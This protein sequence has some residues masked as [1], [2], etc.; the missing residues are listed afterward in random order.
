MC[1]EALEGLCSILN[2]QLSAL[3]NV[4]YWLRRNYGSFSEYRHEKVD[5]D[6]TQGTEADP[7]VTRQRMPRLPPRPRLQWACWAGGGPALPV[8]LARCP[9]G[10]ARFPFPL[11]WT[12][13]SSSSSPQYNICEQMVQIGRTICASS[14][15][16][17][18]TAIVRWVASACS[19]HRATPC[20]MWSLYS[21]HP[22]LL[23]IL[24][25]I[26]FEK[27]SLNTVYLTSSHNGWGSA[28]MI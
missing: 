12:C 3:W 1:Q 10:H 26:Y 19:A 9:L 28:D 21:L 6:P 14:R 22:H 4:V 5:T 8:S 20:L 23:W 13:T 16:W 18:A 24:P 15:S 7:A 25:F 17:H 27:H 2:Q 11:R